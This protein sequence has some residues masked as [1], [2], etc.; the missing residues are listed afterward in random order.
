MKYQRCPICNGA[1][2]VSGGFFD[3]AG[4]CDF[5]TS[6][7]STETCRVCNGSGIILETLTQESE[8][9]EI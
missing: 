6:G 5:W 8:K 3:R 1:G 4:D 9:D 7:N 2:Q